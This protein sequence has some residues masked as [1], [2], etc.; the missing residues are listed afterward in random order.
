MEETVEESITT[1]IH[2]LQLN[3]QRLDATKGEIME[4]LSACHNMA[5]NLSAS[6]T[7]PAHKLQFLQQKL[8]QIPAVQSRIDKAA[9][10]LVEA[11][12]SIISLKADI[13]K[14]K[15]FDRRMGPRYVV[16]VGN[17][18]KTWRAIAFISQTL[19]WLRYWQSS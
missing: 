19:I 16:A 14:V 9:A 7:M 5:E 6:S 3:T 18:W 2:N 10:K 4:E 12:K 17:T 8:Q 13:E 15:W 1:L 11:H